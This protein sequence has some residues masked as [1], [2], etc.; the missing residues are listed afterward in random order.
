MHRE[1]NSATCSQA[2]TPSFTALLLIVSVETLDARAKNPARS[3]LA[4]L[5]LTFTLQQTTE[6]QPTFDGLAIIQTLTAQILSLLAQL[7]TPP[8]SKI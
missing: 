7:A 2:V 8:I 5:G 4:S 6:I 1:R 3:S